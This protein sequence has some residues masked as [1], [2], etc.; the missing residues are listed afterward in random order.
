[1]NTDSM[2]KVVQLDEKELQE[3]IMEVKETVAHTAVFSK[4]TTKKFTAA[5]MW[6]MKRRMRSASLAIPQIRVVE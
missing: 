1:M 5:Q 6:N 4:K 3:L 2:H